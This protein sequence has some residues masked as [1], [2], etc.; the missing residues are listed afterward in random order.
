MKN[1][2]ILLLTVCFI[3][4]CNT[5]KKLGVYSGYGYYYNFDSDGRFQFRYRGHLWGDTSAGHFSIV[6]D[7]INFQYTY[8]NY[9][10]IIADAYSKGSQPPV[11]VLFSNSIVKNV[12]RDRGILKGKR[13]YVFWKDKDLINKRVYLMR[14]KD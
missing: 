6:R 4:S 11:D 1:L 7:T 12:R 10:S 14:R 2:L 8:N 5:Q 13:L 3:Q 9:D